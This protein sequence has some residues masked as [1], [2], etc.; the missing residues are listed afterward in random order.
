MARHRKDSEDK[1]LRGITPLEDMPKID[2][3]I[4]PRIGDKGITLDHDVPF[5]KEDYK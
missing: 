3:P 2:N 5:N 1:T 4:E